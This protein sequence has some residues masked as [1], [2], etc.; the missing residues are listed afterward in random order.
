[1]TDFYKHGYTGSYRGI[2]HKKFPLYLTA[3]L[4]IK[5]FVNIWSNELNLLTKRSMLVIVIP[6]RAEKFKFY[7]RT[8]FKATYANEAAILNKFPG[9]GILK[10]ADLVV[11]KWPCRPHRYR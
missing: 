2:W 8:D 7:D 4:T 9:F 6:K 10:Y 1:M 3:N 5:E 11:L